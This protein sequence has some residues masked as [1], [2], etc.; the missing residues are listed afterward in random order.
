MIKNSLSV[1]IDNFD[2]IK[3]N[4][5]IENNIIKKKQSCVKSQTIKEIEIFF[6]QNNIPQTEINKQISTTVMNELDKY[7]SSQLI[8][9]YRLLT[10]E[11][12]LPTILNSQ[13]AKRMIYNYYNYKYPNIKLPFEKNFNTKQ[14][15]IIKCVE[16][17]NKNV[18]IN[19]GPGTGKTTMLIELA[20]R[21]VKQSKKVLYIS[22]VNKAINEPRDRIILYPKIKFG[23]KKW[24]TSTKSKTKSKT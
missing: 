19:A 23:I 16:N 24:E 6:D 18:V 13:K 8:I 9:A 4:T 12:F 17:D 15:N 11:T 7:T 5:N 21:L 1:F 3:T 22:Y 10:K 20:Y 14:T 2:G